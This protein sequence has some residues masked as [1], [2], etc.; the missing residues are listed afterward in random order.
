MHLLDPGG[1]PYYIEQGDWPAGGGGG[2]PRAMVQG[3]EWGYAP[4]PAEGGEGPV[5]KGGEKGKALGGGE[6]KKKGKEEGKKK[7]EEEE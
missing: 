2:D 4:R 1:R 7:E 5:G 6:K 3:R